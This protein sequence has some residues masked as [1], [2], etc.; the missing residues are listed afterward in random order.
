MTSECN[1]YVS[2]IRYRSYPI[3]Q[4]GRNKSVAAS[5]FVSSH[6]VEWF[7]SEKNHIKLRMERVD[8]KYK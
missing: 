2:T 1:I 4:N 5:R 7:L 3:T 6:I 8:Y